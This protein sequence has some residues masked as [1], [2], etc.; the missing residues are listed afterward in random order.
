MAI[1]IKTYYKTTPMDEATIAAAVK[2]CADQDNQIYQL[3]KTFGTLTSWDA[4]DLYNELVGPILYTSV[5]RSINT[6]M[7]AKVVTTIGTIRGDNGR[8]NNLYQI[9]DIQPDIIE[10]RINK[11]IPNNIKIEIEYLNDNQ[12]DIEKMVES[13]LNKMD[14]F[15]ETFINK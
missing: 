4:Y 14:K 11:Y 3:F 5:G 8:P 13:L 2:A 7:K 9:S 6:L 1:Q 10:R 15:T 12:L